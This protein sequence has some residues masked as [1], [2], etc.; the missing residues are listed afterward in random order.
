MNALKILVLDDEKTYRDELKEFLENEHFDVFTAAKPSEGFKIIDDQEIDILLLDIRL[1]EMNGLQ[2]LQNVKQKHPD[3]ETIMLTGHGDMDTVIQAMRLG[4][5]EFFTKPFRLI[6]IK[7]A[8]QRTQRYITLNNR[9]RYISQTHNQI[10]HEMLENSGTQILGI[11]PAV[12]A[13][14]NLMSKVAQTDNTSVLITGESGTGKVLVA[15][16][17]HHLSRRSEGYFYAVNCSA[18]P[19]SLF[20]SEFFGYKKGAFTGAQADKAGWFELANGGTLFLDEVVEMQPQMQAKLLRVLEER[21]V[22]R[23]GAANDTP[24]DVRI[25]AATNQNVAQYLREGKFR[26]DLYYRLNSFEINLPPLRERREDIPCLIDHFVRLLSKQLGKKIK[27]YAPQIIRMLSNYNFPGNIRELRNMIER[28]I[29][30]C[31]TDRIEA[32]NLSSLSPI[33]TPDAAVAPT[34]I[35]QPANTTPT[36]SPAEPCTDNDMFDLSEIERRAIIR[37][38]ERT[39]YKKSDTAAL[40]NITRQALDRRLEKHGIDIK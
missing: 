2:M 22:R 28:A 14:V 15:R 36:P 13:V 26:S 5:M 32:H 23:I 40:L 25:V 27:G 8:I 16:G 29:I 39:G 1:P 7:A 18:I 17:I 33:Y 24:I 38:L 30:L 12:N 9:Y 31:D 3:I 11:S 6:D 37:A 20:E 21:R 35:E 34:P 10:A 19:E 4:A